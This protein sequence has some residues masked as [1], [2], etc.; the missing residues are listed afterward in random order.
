MNVNEIGDEYLDALAE[1]KDA[2]HAWKTNDGDNYD[3]CGYVQDRVTAE[4]TVAVKRL[5]KATK[6]LVELAGQDP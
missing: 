5:A 1:A 4:F 2:L 3:P 6:A